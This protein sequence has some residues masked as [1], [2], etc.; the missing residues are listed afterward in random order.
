MQSCQ[1]ATTEIIAKVSKL[2]ILL[3]RIVPILHSSY[4]FLAHSLT[5]RQMTI[6]FLLWL[7]QQL[8]RLLKY[9]LAGEENN[10]NTFPPLQNKP[11][12]LKEL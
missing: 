1:L 10:Q 9:N 8:T 12:N 4:V 7:V 2:S 11:L 5:S 6:L 3:L